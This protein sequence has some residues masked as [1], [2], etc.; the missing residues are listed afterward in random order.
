MKKFLAL[1]MAFIMLFILSACG[2]DKENAIDTSVPTGAENEIIDNIEVT[3]DVIPPEDTSENTS[4]TEGVQSTE[5]P[6]ETSKPAETSNSQHTHSYSKAT[7]TQAAKCSCGEIKSPALG[8]KFSEATCTEPQ[9][10]SVCGVAEGSALGHDWREATVT[11]PKT[12]QTCGETEGTVLAGPAVNVNVTFPAYYTYYT[13]SFQMI[14]CTAECYYDLD[15]Y[16]IA[17]EADIIRQNDSSPASDRG[18]LTLYVVI[19][20]ENGQLISD[21]KKIVSGNLLKNEQGK[22]NTTIS[23]PKNSDSKSYTISFRAV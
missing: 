12:C 15:R 22:C 6:T 9:K 14:S 18:N 5:K 20:D 1:L 4:Y 21:N 13:R 2:K 23:L 3:D 16:C 11:S 7:C 19:R 17:I 10:C 8:H